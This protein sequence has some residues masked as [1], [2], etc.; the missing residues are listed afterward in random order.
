VGP[1]ALRASELFR[2]D[3]MMSALLDERGV[4]ARPGASNFTGLA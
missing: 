2:E 4:S 1:Q 3:G